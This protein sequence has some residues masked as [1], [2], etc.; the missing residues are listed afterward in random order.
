MRKL[1]AH[2][3]PSPNLTAPIMVIH[4]LS[5]SCAGYGL[6]LENSARKYL[7]FCHNLMNHPKKQQMVLEEW[8]DELRACE[9]IG[10]AI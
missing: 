10:R 9:K 8:A 4:P 3:M 2:S 5:I 7:A 6:F 1:F